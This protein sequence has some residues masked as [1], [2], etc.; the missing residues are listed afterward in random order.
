MRGGD[1]EVV[2]LGYLACPTEEQGSAVTR[3]QKLALI[4]GFSLIL[5]VGVLISDHLSRART[6]TIIADTDIDQPMVV[7]RLADVPPGIGETGLPL[8]GRDAVAMDP[9]TPVSLPGMN[10]QPRESINVAALLPKVSDPAL[11]DGRSMLD[12]SSESS[13]VEVRMTAQANTSPLPMFEPV[14]GYGRPAA[15][16]S[17]TPTAEQL[18]RKLQD[19]R[20]QVSTLQPVSQPVKQI[21]HVVAEGETL[22]G[23]A[24][25]YYGNGDL[26][27]ELLKANKSAADEE[28]RVFEGAKLVIPQRGGAAIAQTSAQVPVQKPA[29]TPS[30]PVT[31]APV[32]KPDTQ[33][34]SGAYGSYTIKKG[35]TLSE[36][37]QEL[38]GTMRRMNELIE[39]NKDQIQDAD[40]IR[41]GMKLRYPRGQRA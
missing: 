4:I 35:D 36:I 10:A 37:S 38:M 14:E 18:A 7:H 39:L 3:E 16:G 41:V 28:G 5:A 23:I 20:S 33:T 12:D 25:K 17:L 34:A 32:T 11:S 8:A 40:D 13:P 2:A 27:P 22:Y 6:D 30:A 24:S 31:Q 29:L 19:D 21:T 15:N 26:W 1:T 9:G